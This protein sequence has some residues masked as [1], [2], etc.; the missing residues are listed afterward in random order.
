MLALGEWVYNQEGVGEQGL[1]DM[2]SSAERIRGALLGLAAGDRIGGPT[3]LALQLAQCL[4]DVGSFVPRPVFRAYYDWWMEDGYDTGP[5]TQQVFGLVSN[6]T[7]RGLAVHLVHR[8]S[9]GMTAG[10]GPLHRALPLALSQSIPDAAL[11]RCAQQEA[12]LTHYDPLAG[13]I[14]AHY[15]HLVRDLVRGLPWDMALK[16]LMHEAPPDLRA[17]LLA[18]DEQPLS[19]G[20]YAPEVLHAAI[21][22]IHH[23]GSATEALA[24]AQMLA[25]LGNYVPVVV[26]ALAG[27]RW[28]AA[29]ITPDLLNHVRI[30]LPLET[31]ATHLSAGW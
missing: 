17:R 22:F 18:L 1:D 16:Q 9:G 10:C 19:R 20:G 8:R 13:D 5:T 29:A 28:G 23:C 24:Q 2:T 27:A 31:A 21:Y 4:E 7:P 26:G 12:K 30:M 3:R 25:G 6:G 15:V 11:T 14:S